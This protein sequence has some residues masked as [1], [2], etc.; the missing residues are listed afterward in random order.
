MVPIRYKFI[1]LL[2]QKAL[3]CKLMPFFDGRY[4]L[5]AP[6]SVLNTIQLK[7]RLIGRYDHLQVTQSCFLI[8]IY[9]HSGNL[10][11][12]E[13]NIVSKNFV[14]KLA[15]NGLRTIYTCHLSIQIVKN[16]FN[17]VNILLPNITGFNLL[18]LKI[19]FCIFFYLNLNF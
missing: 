12:I 3:Q 9:S 5:M 4:L 16:R 15:K 19:Q 8:I 13:P 2:V 17:N 7:V 11:F 10:I 14:I 1:F 6:N 18:Y